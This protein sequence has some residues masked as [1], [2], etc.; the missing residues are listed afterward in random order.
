[1]YCHCGRAEEPSV[2]FCRAASGRSF[3][4]ARLQS[5][6]QKLKNGSGLWP[7]MDRETLPGAVFTAGGAMQLSPAP[8]HGVKDSFLQK[9]SPVGRTGRQ[10]N[11]TPTVSG[12]LQEREY[13]AG[14]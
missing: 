13:A 11:L 7:P 10:P 4:T 3:L 14:A 9:L 1:M 2:A 12:P 8:Q 6:R 5:R